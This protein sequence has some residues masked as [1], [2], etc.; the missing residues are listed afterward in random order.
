MDKNRVL[1]TIVCFM[2]FIL[3]AGQV[4]AGERS[5][6]GTYKGK[7]TSGTFQRST[8]RSPG[9]ASR[10]TTWQNENGQ[11][12]RHSDANWNKESG[13]GDYSSKTDLAN[14]KTVER[15]GAVKRNGKG[16]YSQD[17]TITGP[18]GK[19]TQVDRT[20]LKNEDGS[21]SVSAA[22]TNEAGETL[23]VAKTIQRTDT[24]RV[25][26]GTYE[27]STGKSGTIGSTRTLSEGQTSTQRTLTNQD[28]KTWKKDIETTREGNTITQGVTTTNPK[29]EVNSFTR[30]ETSAPSTSVPD[31]SGQDTS[32]SD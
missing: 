2:A 22:Y 3:V 27:T 25:V 11:G 16:S 23:D 31:E 7:K 1:V 17:G 21:R 8:Q 30:S 18:R 9:K 19:T 20:S 12:I 15:Q 5:R 29:G 14:G 4:F 10:T 13:A 6:S 28:G 32:E 24:G 26:E